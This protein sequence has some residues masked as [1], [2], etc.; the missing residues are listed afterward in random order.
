MMS[1]REQAV[2]D[3]LKQFRPKM[4]RDLV[5]SH[6]L[7]LTAKKMW[8]D[9]TDQLYELTVMQKL[10][11]N[12]AEELVREVAFPPSEKDQPELGENPES[13]DP[14]SV[15]TTASPKKTTSAKATSAPRPKIT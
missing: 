14:T 7:E 12:Q 15:E 10:P 1:S 5:K 6:N 8:S 13:R 4:Y 11:H 2:A 9:Y 3:H